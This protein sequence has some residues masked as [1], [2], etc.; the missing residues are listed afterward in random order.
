MAKGKIEVDSD[1]AETRRGRPR[2]LETTSA[3]L[4]SAYTPMATTGLAATSIDA[5]A[6]HSNRVMA[7]SQRRRRVIPPATGNST[8]L[9]FVKA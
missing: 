6:R 8:L 1:T 4:Q 3:I 7:S 5:V 2:S 9:A